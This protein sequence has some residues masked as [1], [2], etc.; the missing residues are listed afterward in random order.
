MSRHVVRLALDRCYV[1]DFQ[2]VGRWH[3]DLYLGLFRKDRLSC[4][5]EAFVP[6]CKVFHSCPSSG[7][8]WR[9]L[10]SSGLLRN[11]CAVSWFY[12][13]SFLPLPV[14]ATDLAHSRLFEAGSSDFSSWKG[15]VQ[16]WCSQNRRHRRGTG[17]G[18]ARPFRANE[19]S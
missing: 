1:L 17:A 18:F 14:W 15:E 10:M 8:D 2:V 11:L 16:C 4:C 19:V 7:I 6:R 3:Y 13:N 12:I 5:Q 9:Q